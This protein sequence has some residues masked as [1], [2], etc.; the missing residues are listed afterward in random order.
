MKKLYFLYSMLMLL[1]IS[2]SS[3]WAAE[4]SWAFKTLQATSGTQS[5]IAW[6]TGKTGSATATACTSTNGLVLY[7]VLLEAV[8]SKPHLHSA[9]QLQM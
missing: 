5:G 6:E 9:V 3:A 7:G 8:I 2:I 1:A 4:V